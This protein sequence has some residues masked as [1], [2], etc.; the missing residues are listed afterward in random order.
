MA[1]RLRP[2]PKPKPYT[3]W[4]GG[5]N[6]SFVTAP[7]D[8]T[9]EYGANRTRASVSK[10]PDENIPATQAPTQSSSGTPR[11]SLNW[12]DSGYNAQ[13]AS[14]QRALQDYETGATTRGQRYGQDYMT[15]L[16]GLGYRPGE[17]FQAM[18]NVL[19]QLDKPQPTAMAALS[20]GDSPA[21]AMAPVSGQ[22]DIKGQYDPYSAAAQGT[23]SRR[24]DFTARG[25][26]RSSDFA[27]T[28]GQFQD[29]LQQQ[30]DAMET[31]RTRFG[32]DLATDVA[33]QRTA[34]QERQQGAQR[35]AM[36]R[37]A[38]AAGRSF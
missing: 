21:V 10:V 15:G 32:Q 24:D 22:F 17:G 20:E 30:L 5:G 27:K 31:S 34:S 4:T 1:G 25:T 35:D 38:M 3:P 14:I 19:D 9:I 26:L 36:L 8:N 29:R 33:Q 18:P 13:I 28:F 23:R 2:P 16:K 11:A 12:R 6:D 7:G 37:A